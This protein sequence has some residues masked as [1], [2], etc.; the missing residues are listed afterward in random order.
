MSAELAVRIPSLGGAGL[1]LVDGNLLLVQTS[2]LFSGSS[3]V[4]GHYRWTGMF[5]PHCG[6]LTTM[7]RA[8]CSI[9]LVTVLLAATGCA[10]DQRDPSAGISGPVDPAESATGV[11]EDPVMGEQP[12]VGGLDLAPETERVDLEVPTFSDPTR[13]DN[14]LFPVG[15]G[16][17]NVLLG[18]VEGQPF[19]SEVTVLPEPRFIEWNGERVETVVS[20]YTAFLG[21][22]IHEVAQD[23]YAQDDDGAVWY[24]G[25]DV[26]NFAD[27]VVADTEGTWFAGKDGP[28]AM[29]MPPDPQVGDVYRPEKIPG[30][31]FEEVTVKS[32]EEDVQGPQGKV[33]DAL[34]VSELHMGGQLEGKTFAPGYGEFYTSGGGDVEALAVGLPTDALPGSTSESLE[35]LWAASTRLYDGAITKQ[36]QQ[37]VE[38]AVKA[39]GAAWST[40][41][42][43][44]VP[45]LLRDALASEMVELEAAVNGTGS[46]QQSVD[47]ARLALD[48]RLR[49]TPREE[50]DLGRLEL[51]VRQLVIDIDR[52]DPAGVAGD[53]ACLDLVR[54]RVAHAYPSKALSSLDEALGGLRVASV[55]G[56]IE[57]AKAQAAEARQIVTELKPL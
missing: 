14:P 15:R 19:R 9:A 48:L 49:Y 11:S 53:L 32:T 45:P 41:R 12:K 13:I 3:A 55:N 26:F 52:S 54:A 57:A 42:E 39:I 33:E 43:D 36:D 20:Q 18:R 35:R 27:G 44:D 6:G 56:N 17:S 37:A 28:A 16:D 2:E 1:W 31:V 40:L 8:K 4:R 7:K 51:W 47:I 50:I 25:E 21:G 23:L 38:S 5:Q 34:R 10:S 24:F 29:I 30:L 46:G 22:R